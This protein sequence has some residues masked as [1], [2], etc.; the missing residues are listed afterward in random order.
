MRR[1]GCVAPLCG[2]PALHSEC[3]CAF[4]RTAKSA[5][6]P[7]PHVGMVRKEPIRSLDNVDTD[8]DD[9]ET[10]LEVGEDMAAAMPTQHEARPSRC[11]HRAKD[12]RRLQSAGS[13]PR[14]VSPRCV[15]GLF[16]VLSVSES[17]GSAKNTG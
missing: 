8:G 12:E 1:L 3:Y 7:D 5:A 16:R 6:I 10:T 9:A 13:V 15:R 14:W 17:N 11:N 2:E 4:D